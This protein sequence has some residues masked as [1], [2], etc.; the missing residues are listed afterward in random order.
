MARYVL[1]YDDKCSFCIWYSKALVN[2]KL[3]SHADVCGFT[4]AP[5]N[6]LSL[7][8]FAKADIEVPLYD[9]LENKIYYGADAIVELATSKLSFLKKVAKLGPINYLLHQGYKLLSYNR[10][11][12]LAAKPTATG[13]Q[14]MNA[15]SYNYKKFFIAICF[16][17][18]VIAINTL[19]AA[20]FPRASSWL[21]LLSGFVVLASVISS[22]KNFLELAMQWQ[23]QLM[24]MCVILIPFSLLLP[25]TSLGALLFLI[26]ISILFTQQIKRRSKYLWWYWRQEKG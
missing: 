17:V 13:Y 25:H 20:N 21:I 2:T 4:N 18:S 8:D 9:S 7:I 14:C 23:L 10:K 24:I 6:A 11:G 19:H 22:N 3:L 15:Y 5:A 12:L 26:I 16:L 1:I